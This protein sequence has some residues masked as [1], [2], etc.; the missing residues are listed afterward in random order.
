MFSWWSCETFTERVSRALDGKL[1]WHERPGYYFRLM[2]CSTSRRFRRQLYAMEEYAGKCGC[3]CASSDE[4]QFGEDAP[5]LS[6]EACEKLKNALRSEMDLKRGECP[7]GSV[8][9]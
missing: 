1:A 2:L 8:E 3:R 9:S 4:P 5:G 6:S 7:E